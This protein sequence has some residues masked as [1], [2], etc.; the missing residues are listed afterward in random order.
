MAEEAPRPGQLWGGKTPQ[1]VIT[2]P[3]T[4]G[5]WGFN[6][7]PLEAGEEERRGPGEETRPGSDQLRLGGGFLC[8]FVVGRDSQLCQGFF[9]RGDRPRFEVGGFG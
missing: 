2:H 1:T 8:C 6:A 4:P 5:G 9:P 3:Q 7:A